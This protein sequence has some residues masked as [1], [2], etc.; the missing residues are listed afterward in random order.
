MQN[1]LNNEP[2]SVVTND[3]DL[4]PLCGERVAAGAINGLTATGGNID[5]ITRVINSFKR[6]CKT[7]VTDCSRERYG[8]ITR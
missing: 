7:V 4:L 3:S 1:H 2:V 6:K 8:D 5:G